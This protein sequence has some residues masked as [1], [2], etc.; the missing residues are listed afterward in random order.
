MDMISEMLLPG[1]SERPSAADVVA[2][3]DGIDCETSLKAVGASISKQPQNM[4]QRKHVEFDDAIHCVTHVK[5]EDSK[6]WPNEVRTGCEKPSTGNSTLL[7]CATDGVQAALR[8]KVIL[9]GKGK[10]QHKV[11]AKF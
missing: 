8:T 4:P 6:E 10:P 9:D 1:P 5:L 2:R 7:K 3:L 11:I